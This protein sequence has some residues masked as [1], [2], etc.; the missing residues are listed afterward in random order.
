MGA[1]LKRPCWTCC[2][3][4]HA[5][6]ERVSLDEVIATADTGDVL[7]FDQN[8]VMDGWKFVTRSNFNH[9]AIVLV[10]Y[11]SG[12]MYKFLVEALSPKSR[13]LPLRYALEIFL[14]AKST[15]RILYRH[16]TGPR[17]GDEGI[18]MANL[19]RQIPGRPFRH[20]VGEVLWACC[21]QDFECHDACGCCCG[22]AV[23]ASVVPAL[24]RTADGRVETS[25]DEKDIPE[26][27]FCSELL[28]HAWQDVGWLDRRRE[29][30][31]F[32]PRH[33]AERQ[34]RTLQQHMTDGVSLGPARLICMDKSK[35]DKEAPNPP[36]EMT[37]VS[38]ERK[39]GWEGPQTD[40]PPPPSTRPS[41]FVRRQQGGKGE[42]VEEEAGEKADGDARASERA[43][44]RTSKGTVDGAKVSGDEKT[45]QDRGA[46]DSRAPSTIGQSLTTAEHA[47]ASVVTVQPSPLE[48]TAQQGLSKAALLASPKS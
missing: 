11:R 12:K 37:V 46:L 45:E 14:R 41:G 21:N 42:A 2:Q 31:L 18:R 29:A 25:V 44:K 17:D 28:A 9:T 36:L 16:A 32:L 26:R 22:A 8:R 19:L 24:S 15:N 35:I 10:M 1:C 27:V 38:S 40:P 5:A 20:S 39:R 30:R 6:Y 4:C 33:F 7:V 34:P 48:D 47:S 3:C 23:D 13:A 43:S